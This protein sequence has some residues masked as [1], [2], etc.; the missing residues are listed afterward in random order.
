MYTSKKSVADQTAI[1]SKLQLPQD[2]GHSQDQVGRQAAIT[3]TSDDRSNA[4]T[5]P[6]GAVLDVYAVL[7]SASLKSIG[8][9]G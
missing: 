9:R 4:K 5:A 2:Q 7:E 8:A 3:F 6:E 1:A